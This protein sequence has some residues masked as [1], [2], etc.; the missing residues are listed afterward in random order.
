MHFNVLESEVDP[1]EIWGRISALS[2]NYIKKKENFTHTHIYIFFFH[3]EPLYQNY[4]I[5]LNC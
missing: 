4:L 3:R 2:Q 5:E 1:G